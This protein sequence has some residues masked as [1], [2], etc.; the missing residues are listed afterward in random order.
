MNASPSQ[1]LDFEIRA[2]SDRGSR[3][4]AGA[5]AGSSG[6]RQRIHRPHGDDPV[7][8]GGRLA[9][10]PDRALR[11]D[12]AGPGRR[13]CSTTARRSSRASRPTPRPTGRSPR[14]GRRPTRPGSTGR[15][16]GSPC[17]SC[18]SRCSSAR[19]SCSWRRTGPGCPTADGHSLYLRPFMIAT[20]IGL[21][22]NQP[23]SSYLFT[24]IASP[25]AGYFGGEVKPGHGLAVGGLHPGRARRH[26]RGQVRRQ[27]RGRVRRPAAGHRP[28]LRPG[29]LAGRGGAA[30]GR[31]DG[32]DEPLLRLRLRRRRPDR[33]AGRDRLAA[34]RHHQ[35]LAAQARS[36]PRHPG[37]RGPDLGRRLA[38]RLRRPARSPRSSRAARPR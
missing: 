34:A 38:S 16:P 28:R 32:R 13:R 23:S 17:P 4:A 2:S 3:G 7:D 9:R 35:G 12:H 6:V 1:E 22:V 26:R 33:D 5:D 31:G 21:G 30:V 18:R 36:G 27:L 14:S 24:L 11:P 8:G 25:V 19:S 37:L 29:R 10:R 20:Q 15:R